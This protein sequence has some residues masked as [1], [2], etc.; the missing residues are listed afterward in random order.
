MVSQAN[1]DV[2]RDVGAAV[3]FQ[4]VRGEEPGAAWTIS[5][6]IGSSCRMWLRNYS[7]PLSRSTNQVS[8]GTHVLAS[9]Y[10]VINRFQYYVPCHRIQGS[11]LSSRNSTSVTKM[12]G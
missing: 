2:E 12:L 6:R 7:Q 8:R 5:R 1:G 9:S 3:V 11:N 4:V 10:L